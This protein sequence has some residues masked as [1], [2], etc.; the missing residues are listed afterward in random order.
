[1]Y[2]IIMYMQ[3]LIASLIYLLFIIESFMQASSVTDSNDDA[4]ISELME[5]IYNYSI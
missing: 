3:C 1:M 5:G 2:E 4:D